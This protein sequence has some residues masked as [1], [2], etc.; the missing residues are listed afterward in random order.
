MLPSLLT[1]QGLLL[2]SLRAC[3]TGTLSLLQ[4]RAFAAQVATV[5]Y[6][7]TV[8][9]EASRYRSHLL[10]PRFKAL[11]VDAAGGCMAAEL[12]L[13][14]GTAGTAQVRGGKRLGSAVCNECT[15]P[16]SCGPPAQAPCCR[17]QNL[18]R[19]CAPK[20]QLCRQGRAL[21]SCRPFTAGLACTQ[22]CN[23]TS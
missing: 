1:S 6:N 22:A 15:P 7:S 20:G 12:V 19:R 21:C 3:G 2:A 11:L 17:R 23:T 8:E 9:E 18:Q 4:R 10:V 13:D 5:A 14:T 16:R